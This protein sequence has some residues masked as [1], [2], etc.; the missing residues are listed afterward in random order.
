M[1]LA[2]ASEDHYLQEILD[3]YLEAFPAEELIEVDD[4]LQMAKDG[5]CQILA[6]LDQDQFV[7]LAIPFQQEAIT[8]LAYF[9]IRSDLRG[10]GYGSRALNLLK[11]RYQ[12]LVLEIETTYDPDSGNFRQRLI[13]KKFYRR[14]Q[15]IPSN[16]TVNCY[17]VEMELMS[18]KPNFQFRDYFN[19]YA[20][21]FGHRE[22]QANIQ[23]E[24]ILLP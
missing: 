12:D 16:F 11:D 7:G 23:L 18:T 19:L 10:H 5:T 20:S 8:Y 21:I 15:L 14:H 3:L 17:G 9:A 24:T 2:D 22:S 4:L 13:R 6:I 1:R